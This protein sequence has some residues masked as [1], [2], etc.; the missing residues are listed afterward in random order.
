[1]KILNYIVVALLLSI[2]G[3]S[4]KED[5]RLKYLNEDAPAP[6]QVSNIKVEN[7]PGGA[8]VTYRLN[9]DEN[10]AYVKAVYEI[11]PGVSRENKASIYT[12]TL[13]LDGFGDTKEYD[14]KLYSVGKNEKVSEPIVVKIKPLTPP[15]ELA[16]G[17]LSL[18]PGFGGVKIRLKNALQANLAIVVDADTVSNGV[19][20]PLQTFYSKAPEVSFSV[21]GLS[22]K[23]MK[24][25]VYL[26]DRWNNKSL[27][28]IKDLTPVFEQKVPKPFKIVQL[29]TDEYTP[30]STSTTVD[31]MWDGLV[32]LG[33]F[34][35]RNSAT[36][37]QWFTVDLNIPVVISRMK[38]H[39]RSSPFNYTGASVKTFELYGSNSPAT[40]GS[41]ASWTLIGKFN[42]FKPSGLPL[43]QVT[44][45]DNT[46]G[47]TNGE[48]FEM[49]DI[50][51]AYRYV[52]F[53]ALETYGGGGQITIAEISF[54][55]KL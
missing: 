52:R 6:Q 49:P 20:R 53:K 15:I 39:Q 50:P 23:S 35:S 47:F 34:A 51:P 22:S 43:G 2:V 48:D 18:E 30:S 13:K 38:V 27:A 7:T 28:I 45:E 17:N 16:Y 26:R 25:S 9:G 4:C 21:R 46:Y 1:M 41:W 19:L 42:S 32:D 36:I 11:Q 3:Q 24:F 8:T 31:K 44:T 14:V 33:I 29:P 54:W 55:G 40:D 5:E 12:D 37:P 10:L